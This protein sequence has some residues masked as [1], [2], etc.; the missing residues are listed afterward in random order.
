MNK[1]TMTEWGHALLDAP[2]YA[3]LTTLNADGS[4]QMSTM[5]V[6]RDGN[7]VLFSTVDGRQKPRNLRRD[8]RA[9]VLLVNPDNPFEYLEIRGTVSL[10][11]DPGRLIDELSQKY[12]GQDYPAESPETVRL[13]VRLT[14]TKVLE[15]R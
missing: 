7:D 13:V 10:T 11:E 12:L 8:P 14:P 9:A 5:W 2:T 4:P 15:R 1:A 6:T 3:V